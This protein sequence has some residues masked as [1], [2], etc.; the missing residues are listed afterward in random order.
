MLTDLLRLQTRSH[1]ERMEQLNEL[2]R[3][4]P[5]HLAQL[6]A[7]YGF[8]APWEEAVSHVLPATDPIRAG[9]AKTPWLEADLE[10]FGVDA[11]QRAALPRA[12][13]IPSVESRAHILGA[14]Y[15]LEGSTLGGQFISQHLERTLGLRD[16][17]GYRFFASYGPE[18]RRQWDAFRAELLATSSPAADELILTSA[19]QTFEHLHAWFSARKAVAA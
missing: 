19:R 15:V 17:Q 7:F 18:V 13:T 4:I 2:P 14:A 9:R 3:T 12:R 16:R 10:F 8:I 6:T 11:A 5:D 1:H